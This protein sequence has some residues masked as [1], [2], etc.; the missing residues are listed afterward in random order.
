MLF[1]WIVPPLNS[2]WINW[3]MSRR[4]LISFRSSRDNNSRLRSRWS[5]TW[6]SYFSLI[7]FLCLF[8]IFALNYIIF[9]IF[10]LLSS[11]PL[12]ISIYCNIKFIK[13][14]KTFRFIP[15]SIIMITFS[16]P[17]CLLWIYKL[18]SKISNVEISIWIVIFWLLSL[19]SY[20]WIL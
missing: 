10:L 17:F 4:A 12:L 8:H 7:A 3:S 11:S 5:W 19:S 14:V 1:Y 9:N 18:M 16:S 6:S 2:W 20:L 15:S 13:L